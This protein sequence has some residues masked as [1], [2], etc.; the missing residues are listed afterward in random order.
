MGAEAAGWHSTHLYIDVSRGMEEYE[1]ALANLVEPFVRICEASG[2]IDRFFFIRYSEGGHHVRLRLHGRGKDVGSELRSALASLVSL[3][4]P[5]GSPNVSQKP[6]SPQVQLTKV[7]WIPYEPEFDRYGGVDGVAVAER[8]FHLS[9]ETTFALLRDGSHHDDSTRLG[10]ALLCMVVLS[11]VFCGNRETSAEFFD[12]YYRSYR[13]VP[14]SERD[15]DGSLQDAF[16]S[17]YSSQAANLSAYVCDAWNRLDCGESLS[18]TLDE[19]CTGLRTIKDELER[20]L[21]L[22]RLVVGRVVLNGW[23]SVLQAIVPSYMH[24]MN[25]RLG[26]PIPVESYLGY[27]VAQVLSD[28]SGASS[29]IVRSAA[30]G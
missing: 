25:N 16:E 14:V 10:R 9:S 5:E 3:K 22:Q 27:M 11:Q 2:W 15:E 7:N 19:Y 21:R 23:R 6:H 26:V 12:G 30:H 8:F 17:A 24:M 28:S 20:L 1:F 29:G 18:P 13:K 4:S